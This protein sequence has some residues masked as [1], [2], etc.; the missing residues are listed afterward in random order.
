MTQHGAGRAWEPL[1]GQGLGVEGLLAE[2][3]AGLDAAVAAAPWP[4]L[5]FCS[6]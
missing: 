3:R 2:L 5:L 6:Y 1:F 4:L